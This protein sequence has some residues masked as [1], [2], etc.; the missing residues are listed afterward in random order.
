MKTR[1]KLWISWKRGRYFD[2]LEAAKSAAEKVRAATGVF[3]CIT[4][5]RES[6]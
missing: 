3:L 4:E 1:F 5:E 2:T 6:K